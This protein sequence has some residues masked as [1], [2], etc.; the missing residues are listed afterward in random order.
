M[1][2]NNTKRELET[3]VE[4]VRPGLFCVHF[5]WDGNKS[6][7]ENKNADLELDLTYPFL[8]ENNDRNSSTN[9][10]VISNPV[11]PSSGAET[12]AF[13]ST[14]MG[15]LFYDGPR[16]QETKLLPLPRP[17]TQQIIVESQT[18]LENRR[19]P[20]VF[21]TIVTVPSSGAGTPAFVQG[22]GSTVYRKRKT[23]LGINRGATSDTFTASPFPNGHNT[24]VILN[25]VNTPSGSSINI[26]SQPATKEETM[27][28]IAKLSIKKQQYVLKV[29]FITSTATSNVTMGSLTLKQIKT[30]PCPASEK[31]R[32]DKVSGDSIRCDGKLENDN[33]QLPSAVWVHLSG[34]E[35]KHR[36]LNFLNSN[37]SWTSDAFD[38]SFARSACYNSGPTDWKPLAGLLWIEFETSNMAE[39]KALKQVTDLYIEQIYCDV[40]FAF[41]GEQQIGGHRNI[42]ATRSP[43]FAALFQNDLEE[44]TTGQVKIED[45]ELDVFKQFLHYIYSGRIL[46]PLTDANAQSLFVVADKY[47]IQDLKEE[48]ITFLLT[49]VKM[50]NVVGLLVWSHLYSVE[51]L[52][53]VVLTFIDHNGKEICFLKDWEELAKNYPELSVLATRRMMDY[54]LRREQK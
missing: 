13:G 47:D 39:K 6:V 8:L 46:T 34:I 17:S 41:R 27:K 25:K 10:V 11:V 38:G 26:S 21:S 20:L 9:K 50:N 19:Q 18:A 52:K 22:S 7:V 42:L 51:A 28:Y 5:Q 14:L 1:L 45:C 37:Q 4:Q 15:S 32:V 48:C 30:K 40:Q 36:Q 44:K 12:P 33:M 16:E 49:C 3:I 35:K 2:G 31:A 29:S 53:E 24:Q 23:I 54:A 43:V